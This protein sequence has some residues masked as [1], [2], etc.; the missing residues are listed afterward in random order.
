MPREVEV[1]HQ[2]AVE[3]TRG[4]ARV[5]MF[6]TPKTKIEIETTLLTKIPTQLARLAGGA[7]EVAC[8]LNVIGQ[9]F[10]GESGAE[11]K[12]SAHLLNVAP[13]AVEADGRADTEG[14]VEEEEAELEDVLHDLFDREGDH[15]TAKPDTGHRVL[16]VHAY[17]PVFERTNDGCWEKM[18]FARS[19]ESAS[20]PN[21][22]CTVCCSV[23]DGR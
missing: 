12:Q 20:S 15:H 5:Q 19:L 6:R 13:A 2:G 22:H 1:H 18:V 21:C 4:V 23:P 7:S 3:A 9:R 8:S 14:L 11:M 16:K 17:V 10:H